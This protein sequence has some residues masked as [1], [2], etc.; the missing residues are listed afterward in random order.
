VD[1]PNLRPRVDIEKGE[2]FGSIATGHHYDPGPAIAYY[3]LKNE[4]DSG[5]REGLIALGAKGS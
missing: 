3:F 5:V 4:R 1:S 2:N